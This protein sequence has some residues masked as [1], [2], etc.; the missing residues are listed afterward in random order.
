[1]THICHIKSE[2][3][4]SLPPWWCRAVSGRSRWRNPAPRSSRRRTS[5]APGPPPSRDTRSRGHRWRGCRRCSRRWTPQTWR[6]GR[7][8]SSRDTRTCWVWSRSSAPRSR[9]TSRRQ[10]PI[11]WR[12]FGRNRP[13]AEPFQN[14]NRSPSVGKHRYHPAE[15]GRCQFILLEKLSR[16]KKISCANRYLCNPLIC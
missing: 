13:R 16:L 2:K 4:H 10:T 9:R 1:M 12:W 3:N 15:K 11:R 7:S 8:I 6:E 5:G 14:S